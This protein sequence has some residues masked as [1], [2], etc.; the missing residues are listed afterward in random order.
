[1]PDK[2]E[3]YIQPYI[4]TEVDKEKLLTMKEALE[5]HNNLNFLQPENIYV[6][7]KA[8]E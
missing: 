6:I 1:M 8:G 5:E 4:P 3:Y 7:K 2:K